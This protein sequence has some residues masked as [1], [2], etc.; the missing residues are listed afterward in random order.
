MDEF[1][2]RPRF[3]V[4]VPAYNAGQTIR[5]TLDSLLSQEFSCWECVVVNDGSVDDTADIVREFRSR[6]SRFRLVEQEN[7]GAAVAHNSGVRASSGEFMVMCAA[8]DLLMPRH[9]LVMDDLIARSADYQIFSCN[10][11]LLDHS[12]GERTV[13]Y[14]DPE[15]QH[16]RSLPFADVIA[17][18]FFSVG[19]TYARELA[20][21]V[22]G[23]RPGAY[24]DDY[25]FWL[26]AMAMG[27]RH[28]Y[29]PELLAVHRLSSFQQ[30]ADLIRVWESDIAAY[31]HLI[32]TGLVTADQR[33][34]VDAAI[35]ARREFIEER[36]AQQAAE[37]ARRLRAAV[38]GRVGRRLAGPALRV[39]SAAASV[40]GL[41]RRALVQRGM[42]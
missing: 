13:R 19:A 14:S 29:T 23:F 25:D 40:S 15:W 26:R 31:R 38:E 12:S 39:I 1:A 34:M 41:V 33:P 32:D 30:S 8:D 22:G 17:N 7:R 16:K 11:Y 20:D 5:E 9:M 36:L 28:R 3:T 37:K 4:V 6:D 10:G 21:S 42:R 2:R 24:V 35:G 27:A 18:C